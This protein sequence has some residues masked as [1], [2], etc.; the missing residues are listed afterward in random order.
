MNKEDTQTGLTHTQM[1]SISNGAVDHMDLLGNKW[2]HMEH[3]GKYS[4]PIC[5]PYVSLYS[6]TPHLCGAPVLFIPCLLFE[7][8]NANNRSRSMLLVNS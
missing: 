7:L 1:Q 2:K 8:T 5:I 6:C 4:G 3:L